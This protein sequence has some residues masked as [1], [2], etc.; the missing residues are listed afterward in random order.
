[1]IATQPVQLDPAHLADSLAQVEQLGNRYHGTPGEARSRD[2]L[3]E[4]F[5]S[6]GLTDVHL[7]PFRYLAY[8]GVSATCSIT[9]PVPLEL[10]CRAVQYSASDDAEGEAIYVGTGTH[11]DFARLDG[12]GVDLAGSVAVAHSIAPFLVAPFLAERRVAALVNVGET[13]DGLIGNFTATLYRPPLE[14]PWVG[15]PVPFPAVTIEAAAGREL[16]STMTSGERVVIRL[17]H[18]AAYVEKDAHN[19]VGSI[20]ASGSEQVVVGGHYD[21]QAEGPCV[22]DNG[23][24]I[25]SIVEIARVLAGADLRRT[26][27]VVGFAVEEV[28]LWGS[29]AYTDRHADEL[30]SIVGMVNLDAV[31]S[32]YPAHRTVWAD[33]AMTAFAVQTA[34]SRGWEPRVVFNARAFE[35]SDNTPFTDAGVP[36]CWVWEFPPIHPYY[37]SSGDVAELVDPIKLA[38]TAGVSAEIAAQLAASGT[39]LGRAR[40]RGETG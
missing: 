21:S 31:A 25:A 17:S 6:V 1:M 12:L 36:S 14:P 5:E 9:A 20:P 8:E 2:W 11:E 28:G 23:T 22:W 3:A 26:V 34:Q 39:S 30:N 38:E 32:R 15:R 33:E 40:R 7:E 37:H 13:P 4:R 18:R 27:V 10:E 35:F 16:V 29:T 24:G 19:V